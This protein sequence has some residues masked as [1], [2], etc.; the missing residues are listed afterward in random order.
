M[1]KS[2]KRKSKKLEEQKLLIKIRLAR[3]KIPGNDSVKYIQS[4]R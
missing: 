2:V 1:K 4:N 3:V